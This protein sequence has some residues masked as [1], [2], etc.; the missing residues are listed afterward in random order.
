MTLCSLAVWIRGAI[1]VPPLLPE[2]HQVRQRNN[3]VEP[4]DVP[5]QER[6]SERAFRIYAARYWKHLQHR[7]SHFP[8]ISLITSQ[9]LMDCAVCYKAAEDQ[10]E[11]SP[12]PY[13]HCIQ[14]PRLTQVFMSCHVITIYDLFFVFLF[15]YVIANCSRL[16]KQFT[17][18]Y[19]SSSGHH[20]LFLLQCFRGWCLRLFPVPCML[21]TYIFCFLKSSIY[22][23]LLHLLSCMKYSSISQFQSLFR[24]LC[25]WR[26][27]QI[28]Q[29]MISS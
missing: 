10:I 20:A 25:L 28:S 16:E 5:L 1:P 27:N 24:V 14:K 17:T 8:L 13:V 15:F 19:S 7:S 2:A 9:P 29:N 4:S 6:Q 3:R 26:K 12:K 11:P 18:S 22:S 21:L 23:D